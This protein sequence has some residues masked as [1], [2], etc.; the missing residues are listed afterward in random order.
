MSRVDWTPES[1]VKDV[2]DLVTLPEMALRIAAMV[3][4][5]RAS[6]ADIGR[7]IGNDAGLTARLLRVANGPAFGNKGNI[8]SISRA[9]AV[10]GVRQ[11]RDL[12]V[13]LTAIRTFDGISNDLI[14][15]ESFWR[16]SVL[17]AVAAGQVVATGN[18]KRIESPFVCGLLHDIGQLVMYSRVPDVSRSS[19]IMA[20]DSLEDLALFKCERTVMGFD[21]GAVGGALA[22]QWGLPKA[23]QECIEFHHEPHR[24]ESHPLE[25]AV[26]HVAN[27]IAVM[28]DI[29]STDVADVPDLSHEALKIVNLKPEDMGP[30]ATLTRSAAEEVIPMMTGQTPKKHQSSVRR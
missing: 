3:D 24:A 5:P 26:V 30:I 10:L 27:S 2:K 4:D 14:T 20:I 15:M 1:L 23:L 13:G 18:A 22:R 28:A 29:G 21:H 7:E 9:I 19:L 12:A 6:A 25:V 8:V 17:C 11:V 16:H